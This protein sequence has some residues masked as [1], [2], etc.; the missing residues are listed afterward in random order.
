MKKVWN[1]FISMFSPA[2]EPIP[3]TSAAPP[4]MPEEVAPVYARQAILVKNLFEFEAVPTSQQLA[5]RVR[6]K[7]MI[8]HQAVAVSNPFKTA[9]RRLE[10]GAY[11]D[12]GWMSVDFEYLVKYPDEYRLF[13]K[14]TEDF[15]SAFGELETGI[16]D[17]FSVL[18][19]EYDIHTN[20][21]VSAGILKDAM[22]FQ[23]SAGAHDFVAEHRKITLRLGGY[24]SM[25]PEHLKKAQTY[26]R[27]QYPPHKKHQDISYF[28]VEKYPRSKAPIFPQPKEN[29]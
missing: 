19:L 14:A 22:F 4:V 2:D 26:R 29:N 13:E 11:T 18:F 6:L 21:V 17:F 9:A 23:A 7:K 1:W 24:F 16:T 28:D 8:E 20:V 15:I 5:K 25:Q 10:A 12:D 27:T 3:T